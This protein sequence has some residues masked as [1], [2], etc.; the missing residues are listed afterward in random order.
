MF[1]MNNRN[2]TAVV[3]MAFLFLITLETSKAMFDMDCCYA[4]SKGLPP[5][6]QITG[7]TEQKSNE[8]CN[9][10]AIVLHLNHMDVCVDPDDKR[11]KQ[12][13]LWL[14]KKLRKMSEMS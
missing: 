2:L 6:K 12:I 13:L 4:Y 8:V 7:Y 5:L 10:H 1:K 11:V 9:L 3:L 14:S